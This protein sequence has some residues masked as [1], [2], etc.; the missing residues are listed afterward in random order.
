VPA[1]ISIVIPVY[2]RRQWVGEAIRSVLAQT[3]RDFELIVWDDGST[4]DTLEF[5]RRT[6][7]DDP[8]VRVVAG[9][10]RGQVPSLIDVIA[11]T[12]GK[13]LGWV[14]SD[15]R[16]AST[17]LAETA[18]VLDARPGVGMVYTSYSAMTEG[19]AV[20]GPGKRCQIP[21]SKDR[22]LIDF[23]TFH[24][25]LIRRAVYDQVGGVET[26]CARAEDY[27]LCLKIS[28]VAEIHHL[29]RPLYDY[30]VHDASISSAERVEQIL[31]AKRAVERALARRGM[32]EEYEL[33]VQIVSQ[34]RL[35]KRSKK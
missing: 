4:D 32:N 25:R 19:G 21:Y 14:D 5:V 33:D 29:K 18:A 34:F 24:F 20:R 17:A 2:N 9:E 1:A 23:M 26:V 15:D 8:R 3:F 22:L 31:A 6:V 28:E 16:L 7:G 10:H 30:R 11:M 12:G 27:D 35:K 13:Y